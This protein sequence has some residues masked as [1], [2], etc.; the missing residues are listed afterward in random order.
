MPQNSRVRKLSRRRKVAY[1]IAVFL[2]SFVAIEATLAVI[3]VRPTAE[4]QDLFVG[5]QPGHKLFVKDGNRFVTNPQKLSF[6][7]DVSFPVGKP[8]DTIRIMSLGGSTTYG[9]PYDNRLSYNVWLEARLNASNSERTWEVI[10]C[11]GISYASYRLANLMEELVEYE[12]DVVLVCT[13]HNEFLEERTYRELRNQNPILAKAIGVGAKFRTF[14]LLSRLLHPQPASSATKSL[15]APEVDTILEQYGPDAYLRDDRMRDQI[16]AHYRASLRRIVSLARSAGAEVIFIQP[17]SNL[18]DFS[19][20][21]SQHAELSLAEERRYER[22]FESARVELDSQLA[23]AHFEEAI[24]IDARYAQGLF[25]YAG[26]LLKAGQWQQAREYFVRAKD[27]DVC[28]LRAPTAISNAMREVAAAADV[29]IV[30]F[31]ALVDDRS[32]TG[33]GYAIPGSES[34]LDHVHP[35]TATHR[36][37]GYELY[38]RIVVAERQPIR[39]LA[40]AEKTK[41]EDRVL[42]SVSPYDHGMALHALA[43]TLS[44]SG[45]TE[46]SLLVIEMAVTQLPSDSEVVYEHAHILDKLGRHEEALGRFQEALRLNPN[47]SLARSRVG[48]AL[49][50]Q[51]D[52]EL[53]AEHLRRAVADTPDRAPIS[54]RI[55]MRLQLA[56]CLKE[57]GDEAGAREALAQ[58]LAIDPTSENAKQAAADL[59]P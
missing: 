48:L 40:T 21:R 12:P 35:N 15:L 24:G 37:L 33:L 39:P 42:S 9:H 28:P 53:A 19:P 23:L 44:W 18:R 4:T 31:P 14:G 26:A 55:R 46:E 49:L 38:E 41:L 43:M 1:S 36:D 50:F 29:T 30:D 34:F 5:F 8:A 11:G 6:F 32:Q 17:A 58:A 10:N 13:G 25:E 27:E 2:L 57:L 54:V 59:F 16:V 3:G 47:N 45:K 22:A 52:Y 56:A 7:N 51:G 20:F